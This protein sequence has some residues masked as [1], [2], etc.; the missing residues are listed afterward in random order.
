MKQFNFLEKTFRAAAMAIDGCLLREVE[1]GKF[2][3]PASPAE[4]ATSPLVSP[5]WPS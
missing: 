4:M 1:M 2:V 3:R 5:F